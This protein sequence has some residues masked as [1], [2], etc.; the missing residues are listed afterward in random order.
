M[1]AVQKFKTEIQ[2]FLT[3][4]RIE[5]YQFYHLTA[6]LKAGENSCD[7]AATCRA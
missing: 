4:S 1:N 3:Q 7:F 5:G 6:I 2:R